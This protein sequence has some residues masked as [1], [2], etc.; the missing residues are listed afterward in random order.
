MTDLPATETATDVPNGKIKSGGS[1]LML[2]IIGWICGS[3]SIWL[4]H[5]GPSYGDFFFIVL[6][7][8]ILTGIIACILHLIVFSLGLS[9]HRNPERAFSAHDLVGFVGSTVFLLI[10]AYYFFF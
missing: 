8:S 10:M 2:S 5:E 6:G 7:P 9:I 1:C 4:W 3:A